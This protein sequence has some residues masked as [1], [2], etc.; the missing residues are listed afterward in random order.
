[1]TKYNGLIAD[2]KRIAENIELYSNLF[3]IFF[4]HF[5]DNQTVNIKERFRYK[6]AFFPHETGSFIPVN[7]FSNC[8]L[9][10]KDDYNN[11]VPWIHSR[12]SLIHGGGTGLFASREFD[13]GDIITIYLGRKLHDG[14]PTTYACNDVTAAN[15]KGELS[16]PF[17]LA[18]L[19]NHAG[20]KT[21][22]CEL[23]GYTIVALRKI[24]KNE[25]ILLCYN[26]DVFCGY[27]A[28]LMD[29]S[30]RTFREDEKECDYLNCTDKTLY[31]T[32]S[33]VQCHYKLCK[34]H[35]FNAMIN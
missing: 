24:R 12:P 2:F 34:L 25:E 10:V 5:T 28:T 29:H 4:D 14:D 6:M 32:C 31:A 23:I 30:D 35:Y 13:K 7:I 3:M 26:R 22:N 11:Y 18:Q 19:I 20:H 27:C 1:M 9:L 17:L 15:M 16:N 33:D 8:E 21:P